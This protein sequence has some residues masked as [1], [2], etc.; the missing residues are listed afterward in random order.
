M[1]PYKV[2]QFGKYYLLQKIAYGGMAEIFLALQRGIEGFERQIIIKRILPHKKDDPK[3]KNMF[4]DEAKIAAQFYHPNIAQIYEF[5]EIGQSYYIAMEYIPGLNLT[6]ILEIMSQQGKR[7]LP[8]EYGIPIVIDITS[9]LSY[10]HNLNVVHRDICAQNIIISEYG[11]AKLIDF[12][13]VKAEQRRSK[14]QPGALK[15]TYGYMSPEQIKTEELDSRSDIFSLGVLLYEITTG[16]HPFDEQNE[17]KLME[18]ILKGKFTPPSQI[19][20]LYPQ[21]LEKIIIKCMAL[22]KEQRFKEAK[23]IQQHLEAFLKNQGIFPSVSKRA[24]FLKQLTRQANFKKG[25]SQIKPGRFISEEDTNITKIPP[26]PPPSKTLKSSKKRT[27]PPSVPPPP[28]PPPRTPPSRTPPPRTSSPLIP[29]QSLLK[30]KF[31]LPASLKRIWQR[32]YS[33]LSLGGL[34]IIIIIVSLIIILSDKSILSDKPIP[35]NKALK[36]TNLSEA[37]RITEKKK[38]TSSPPFPILIKIVSSPPGAKIFINNMFTGLK[39]PASLAIPPETKLVK[40]KLKKRGFITV[41]KKIQP[42][43]NAKVFFKL[44]KKE[45]LK[46]P[47]KPISEEEPSS[48]WYTPLQAK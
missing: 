13:V 26:P 8:Y 6:E 24:E 29:P 18:L 48:K 33:L 12:G 41:K 11:P 25:I 7:G 43:Q 40:V 10:I 22:K 44:K 36:Q 23:E 1:N 31:K 2:E 5:G 19:I 27:L 9:A 20:P 38:D 28:I 35:S 45:E 14:T 4:I 15:G 42:K 34:L 16:V 47:L 46:T 37:Q 3:F 21:E 30:S 17:M 39:T 32:P